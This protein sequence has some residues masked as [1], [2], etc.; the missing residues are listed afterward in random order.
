MITSIV[1]FIKG[2][3]DYPAEYEFL[4]YLGATALL[5]ILFILAIDFFSSIFFAIFKRR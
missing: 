4:L 3:I 5:L 2:L 1:D